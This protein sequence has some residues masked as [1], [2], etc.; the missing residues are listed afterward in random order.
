MLHLAVYFY[1]LQNQM[2]DGYQHGTPYIIQ[3]P[4]ESIGSIPPS[5]DE[6]EPCTSMSSA[7]DASITTASGGQL[8]QTST[9]S[10]GQLPQ[11]STW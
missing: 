5:G 2:V 4:E 11:T 9:S 10:H 6:I 7:G 8:P 1:V 3:E